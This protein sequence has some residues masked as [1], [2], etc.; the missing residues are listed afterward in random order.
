MKRENWIDSWKGILIFLVVLGH[1][2]GMLC[3]Y[4]HGETSKFMSLCYKWI[5]LFHMPAFFV[6]VGVTTGL[7]DFKVSEVSKFPGFRV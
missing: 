2:V 5:Y 4:T 3:H 6:V 7:R 1:V